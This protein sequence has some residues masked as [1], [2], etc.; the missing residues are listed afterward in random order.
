MDMIQCKDCELYRQ[1]PDGR[2][3]FLCDPFN[4][5][6]EAECL[7]KWQ[8]LRLDMIAAT[9]NSLALA[10]TQMA[11]IQ[12]KILK[13]IRRELEDIDES[14]KW[15][16]DEEADTDPAPFEKNDYPDFDENPDE[17]Q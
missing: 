7:A 6:K 11:P 8:L 10:Q 1:E 4:N 13:Y 12:D 17:N 3:V 15:K 9:Q 5:V 14:E 2:R 16:I